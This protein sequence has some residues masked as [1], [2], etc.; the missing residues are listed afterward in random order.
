MMDKLKLL[1]ISDD[2]VPSGFG[3][4][5]MHINT[6]AYRRGWDVMALSLAYDGL[7]PAMFNGSPLPYHVGTVQGKPDWPNAVMNVINAWQPDVVLVIQDFPYGMQIFNSPA[8]WSQ[9][10][11]VL[12]TPIDGVPIHPDW[13]KTVDQTD[14]TMTKIGRASCRERV[15]DYV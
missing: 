11:R 2:G 14:A 7:L 6:H 12:I 3:R 5:S 1:T 9:R 4:I 15:S 8:D 13:L 10:G